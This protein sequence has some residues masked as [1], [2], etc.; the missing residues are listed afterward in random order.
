M[1]NWTKAQEKAI[2]TKDKTLLISAAA[3]SGKTTVLIER[4]IR[5]LTD[6]EDPTDIN[7]LLIVTFTRAAALELKQR[8][9][10][11]LSKAISERPS[12]QRLFK[13]LSKLGGA[14][15]S[16]IDSFYSDVVRQ[17]A[18][19]LGIPSNLRIADQ[20]EL[21]KL[22]RRAMNEAI[23][24]GYAGELSVDAED[25]ALTADA[26]SDMR[27]DERLCDVFYD[28]YE[29]LTGHPDSIEFLKKC[30]ADYESSETN[31]FFSTV[32]GGI[33]KE[34][35][36]S[37]LEYLKRILL[38]ATDCFSAF[39]P[40]IQEAYLSDLEFCEKVLSMLNKESYIKIRDYVNTFS[41]VRLKNPKAAEKTAQ[42]EYFSALRKEITKPKIAA[43]QSSFFGI[44]FS[45]KEL[46]YY[47][48]E[49]AKRM[50]S[51]YALFTKFEEIY[52]EEKL[53]RGISEFR[54]VKLWAYKLLVR[55]DGTPT[56]L[57]L[58]IS[59]SYD[60]I[61]IDEYQDVDSLQDL[62][63]RSI[64]K[65]RGRFMVGDVK[66][67]IYGFRGAEPTLFMGYRNAFADITE[68]ASESDDCTI[69]MS[70]N[71]RCD[72]SIIDFANCVCS[73]IFRT[74]SK[75]VLYTDGD[76]LIF[77]KLTPE[78]YEPNAVNV[79]LIDKK[80]SDTKLE[81]AEA[82]YIAS[83][84][85]RLIK[86]EKK[87]NGE[88]ITANDIAVLSRAYDFCKDVETA[89]DAYGIKHSTE[90]SSSFFDDA[91]VSLTVSLLNAIDNPM[92]DIHLA[93]VLMSPLF[94]FDA[95][96]LIKIQRAS[97]R[98]SSLYDSVLDYST[99]ADELSS[100]CKSFIDE[101]SALRADA[102]ILSA[103]RV[104]MQVYSHFSLLSRSETRDNLMKL[105][106][107]ARS[108]E[109][110][111]FK[112]LYGYTKHLTEM[113]DNGLSP[114]KTGVK[115]VDGVHLMTIH[116]SKGLEFP[117]CFVGGCGKLFNKKDSR[118]P[119]LY[120]QTLGLATDISDE[121]GFCKL[122]TPY[123]KA[124]ALHITDNAIEEEMRVLYVA[125]TR[126]RERLYVTAEP[127]S[128]AE[129]A[130]RNAETERRYG[131][132]AGII[133][134]ASYISWVLASLTSDI[135]VSDFHKLTVIG[136]DDIAPLPVPNEVED[137]PET[138]AEFDEALYEKIK[139]NL[140]YEYPYLHIANIPA[141]L[142]VSKL[143]P[144]V[145]DRTEIE[146]ADAQALDIELPAIISM[147]KFMGGEVK[148]TAAQRGTA[149][150]TFLQFC[151]FERAR[152][153]GVKEELSRLTELGFMPRDMA[154]LVNVK[155]AEMFFK[156]RLFD[157]ITSARRVWREQRFNILL[158]A[159]DFTE[160]EIYAHQIEGEKLLVQ[161]VMDIFFETKDG[162]LVLCDYKTD[163]LT[164]E[165]CNDA[166]LAKAKLEAAHRLQLSYYA[167]A[168]CEIFGKKPDRVEIYSLPFEDSFE[169]KV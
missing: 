37:E 35:V 160:D 144:D 126:G 13:Q 30:T 135:S 60:C 14:H 100:R 153:N 132:R 36:R 101:L 7:R 92:R 38:D 156:S 112:G 95:D 143:T 49:S 80:S 96:M 114:E 131:K 151:D 64:A 90:G 6:P 87:A 69:F 56:D 106:E 104:L 141:K 27:N 82:M 52:S 19:I 136:Y 24:L 121:T 26:L 99:G 97:E 111:S 109:G 81:N 43:I 157:E 17:N 89:L 84:I 23:E 133:G 8:I 74:A 11:A 105:Y 41:S 12:D 44:G 116:K 120:S 93:A 55:E 162:K 145:L 28:I 113:I 2:E 32:Y 103:D 129:G 85:D 140:D 63:F 83:E 166:T 110:D 122:R 42:T 115:D 165:E 117:V 142:S 108:F 25:F 5:S 88:P 9:S 67:S 164:K 46:K 137:T 125:L 58:N 147:P 48:S 47:A 163:Y 65:P 78:G 53:S 102:R 66:Q 158:D 150:H 148:P 29:K 34:Y 86:T 167:S 73:Y 168:L 119:I 76:D 128:G 21:I 39:D 94:G 59:E 75:N 152:L 107:D 118:K 98:K 91:D 40:S 10:A 16:T 71:F 57:A 70:E 3:G 155:Q 20:P 149:T 134:A 159:S 45:D 50:R 161:G 72:K 127:S 31:D 62:I 18:Q 154:E 130:L 33:I 139:S 123:R 169:I 77:S 54:D 124:L 1:A 146:E 4:I 15:I 68:T 61:Y 22:Q 138:A 51:L 79:V